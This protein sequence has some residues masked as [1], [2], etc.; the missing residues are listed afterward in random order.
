MKTQ[1][2]VDGAKTT[3]TTG[4]VRTVYNNGRP[5]SVSQQIAS[6][7]QMVVSQRMEVERLRG[8]MRT[9]RARIF[10][11]QFCIADFDAE[12]ERLVTGK[13]TE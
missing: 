13:G 9:A 8:E 1:V 5:C 11:A 12:T 7:Q 6:L 10:R 3:V 4:D 2:V